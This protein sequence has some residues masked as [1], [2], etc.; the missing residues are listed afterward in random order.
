[1][2]DEVR[3]QI[4]LQIRKGN[5]DYQSKPTSFVTDFEGTKGPTPA[6]IAVLEEG[7]DINLSELA[8]LGG[9]CWIQNLDDAEFVTYGIMNNTIGVFFPLGEALPGEVYLLRIS[10]Y[11][12]YEFDTTGTGTGTGTAG[13][14]NTLHFRSS[15]GEVQVR[16]D[17]FDP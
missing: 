2:A 14:D 17:A 3:V 5:L 15:A 16:I 8:V 7:T 11:L 13:S 4:S 10:R 1:M 12:G 9:L 6:S